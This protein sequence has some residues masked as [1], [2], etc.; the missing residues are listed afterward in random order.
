MAT[1]WDRWVMWGALGG[2]VALGAAVVVGRLHRRSGG[3]LVLREWLDH[4]LLFGTLVLAL[5]FVALVSSRGKVWARSV[6]GVVVVTLGLFTVPF[7]FLYSVLSDDLT[8]TRDEAAPGR[9]DRRLVVQEGLS[10]LGPDPLYYVYVDDGSGLTTRRWEVAFID[11][12]FN[13]I[14]ALAWAGP[15]QLRLV[16]A[17]KQTHLIRIADN[18]RPEPTIND[19]S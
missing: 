9:P 6:L 11:G 1:K 13:G 12:D 4:P 10:G 7:W 17:D 2:A 15:D 5:L 18:G 8:T 16:T 19:R 3:L 14:E